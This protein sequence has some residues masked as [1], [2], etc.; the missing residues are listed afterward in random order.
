MI[1]YCWTRAFIVPFA[2]YLSTL[3]SVTNNTLGLILKNLLET[4]Y[5]SETNYI[6]IYI[7]SIWVFEKEKESEKR[8]K[9]TLALEEDLI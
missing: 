9:K 4:N 5:T 2:C 3:I 8:N 6:Y 1:S 7:T